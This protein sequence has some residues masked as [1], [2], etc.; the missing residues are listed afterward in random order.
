M[1]DDVTTLP[2]MFATI[3]D[4][5]LFDAVAA[6]QLFHDGLELLSYGC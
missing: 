6:W 2:A 3:Y 5:S 4:I 1:V